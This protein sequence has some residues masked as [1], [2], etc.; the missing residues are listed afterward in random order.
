MAFKISELHTLLS[1]ARIETYLSYFKDEDDLSLKDMQAYE[2][3]IW[4]IQI[5]AALLEVISLYEV[6]LRNAIINALEPSYMPYSIL[7]D[8]FIRALKPEAREE[9]LRIVNKLSSHKTYKF[10]FTNGRSQPLKI[11]TNEISPGKVVAELNF[12]FWENMLSQTHRERW[13]SHFN[14]AFPNACISSPDERDLIVNEIHNITTRVRYLRNRI[15]HHEPIFD[16]NKIDLISVFN[17]I[18]QVLCYI[19]PEI[20]E[21]LGQLERISQTILRK[22]QKGKGLREIP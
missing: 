13:I 22:P 20:T 4:N 14:K 3:Y 17:E 2:L 9:L 21:I 16:E 10:H 11:D 5:S 15:C 8:R 19:S 12:I 18:K 7:H 1:Q 6:A